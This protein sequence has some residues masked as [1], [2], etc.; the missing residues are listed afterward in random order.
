MFNFR[1]KTENKTGEKTKQELYKETLDRMQIPVEDDLTDY[2][3]EKITVEEKVAYIDML[4]D[5]TRNS[6]AWE[7][8]LNN[9]G[10]ENNGREP[11][12]VDV[13]NILPYQEEET[14]IKDKL[15]I[16][17]AWGVSKYYLSHIINYDLD[18]IGHKPY[19]YYYYKHMGIGYVGSG[20]NHRL[21]LQ[22]IQNKNKKAYIHII[23]DTYLLENYDT[24]GEYIYDKE[25][26][27]KLAIRN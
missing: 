18:F 4:C 2:S 17:N 11:I 15:F 27:E 23:D 14:E 5:L 10:N 20:G 21:L 13:L 24:D 3:D 16:V 9:F 7:Y 6:L 26:K 22:M 1:R 25:Y 19:R 8:A 12:D